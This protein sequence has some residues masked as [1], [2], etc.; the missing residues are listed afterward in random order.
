MLN[1]RNGGVVHPAWLL[2]LLGERERRISAAPDVQVLCVDQDHCQ[3]PPHQRLIESRLLGDS[4]LIDA[5][6][7][8]IGC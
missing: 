3:L 8:Q 2:P 5:R 7:R 4:F 6:R 1:A